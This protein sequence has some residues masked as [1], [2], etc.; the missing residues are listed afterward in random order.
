MTCGSTGDFQEPP[1][2]TQLPNINQL[3][4]HIWTSSDSSDHSTTQSIPETLCQKQLDP[5]HHHT[6][7]A[8]SSSTVR[9]SVPVFTLLGDDYFVLSL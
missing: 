9:D 2:P 8:S 5:S 4:G 7:L 1:P 6:P 3:G